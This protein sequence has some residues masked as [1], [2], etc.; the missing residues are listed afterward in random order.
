[1]PCV[2]ALRLLQSVPDSAKWLESGSTS[3]PKNSRFELPFDL[4]TLSGMNKFGEGG[5][6]GL[7]CGFGEGGGGGVGLVRV[8]VWVW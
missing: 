8:V 2:M 5:G 4:R 3:S 7:V 6:G 1:M